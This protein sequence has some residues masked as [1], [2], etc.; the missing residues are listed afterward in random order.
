MQNATVH[1]VNPTSEINF[2]PSSA[3][4]RTPAISKVAA[5]EKR[6]MNRRTSQEQ[7]SL[8]VTLTIYVVCPG[9]MILS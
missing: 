1:Y 9:R 7:S 4:F 3:I 5:E 2:S 8:R 6:P